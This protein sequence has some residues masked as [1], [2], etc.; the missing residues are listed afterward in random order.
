MWET[1]VPTIFITTR[2]KSNFDPLFRLYVVLELRNLAQSIARPRLF[3]F[4]YHNDRIISNRFRDM[5]IWNLTPDSRKA[6][7]SP[8]P[9]LPSPLGYMLRVWN[10]YKPPSRNVHHSEEVVVACSRQAYQSTKIMTVDISSY[11]RRSDSVSTANKYAVVWK[12]VYN[13]QIQ[14]TTNN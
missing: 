8:V 14:R 2:P 13:R 4:E 5:T 12:S 10:L 6:R 3:P 9:H 7:D 11:R 1:I